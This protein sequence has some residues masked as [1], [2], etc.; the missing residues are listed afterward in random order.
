M[1]LKTLLFFLVA[2]LLIKVISNLFLPDANKKKSNVRFFYQTY[3][4]VRNQQKKQQQKHK[5]NKNP[6]E[7]IDDIEEAEYE[8]VTE[9]KPDSN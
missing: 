8:D 3:K 2:Y 5:Q 6:D 1:I 9:E 7:R 4:N